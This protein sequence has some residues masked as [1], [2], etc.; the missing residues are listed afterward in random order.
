MKIQNLFMA[1]N[2][3]IQ[4]LWGEKAIEFSSE[5]VDRDDEG[6][7]VTPY[8]HNGTPLPLTI[9]MHS[10]VVCN[11]F[12]DNPENGKRISWRNVE[13]S[14]VKLKGQIVY[15]L[16]TTAFNSVG[17]VDERRAENRVQ[18]TKSA[19]LYDPEAKK[20]VPIRIHDVSDSGIAFHAPI[21]FQPQTNVLVVRFS[22]IVNEQTFELDVKSKI[23]RTKKMAGTV[24]YG[25]RVAEE[26][27]E[28]LLYGCLMR[29]KKNAS[30]DK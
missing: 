25:C 5:I 3:I 19:T 11:I 20:S 9:N 8:L 24:F 28:Y 2:M 27:S 4:I 12:G 6:L 16:K 22:D 26:N 10:G 15:H 7:Y 21:T 29:M 18:I 17:K 23:V 13:L 14:T 30:E 1:K